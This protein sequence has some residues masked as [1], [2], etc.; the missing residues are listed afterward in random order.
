[1]KKSI[2]ILFLL[3]VFSVGFLSANVKMNLELGPVYTYF[4]SS[5]SFDGGHKSWTTHTGGVNILFGVEFVKNFGVY[6][7]ANFA[8][9]KEYWDKFSSKKHYYGD[10]EEVN[11]TYA[12]DSQFGFFYVFRPIKKLDLTLGAGIGIG[13]SGYKHTYA[14][15]SSILNAERSQANIGGGINFTV[16]Y[17]FTKMVGIYGGV[18]DTLYAPVYIKYSDGK[19]KPIESTNISGKIAN[20]FNI[21]AG[22]QLVF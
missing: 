7:N 17:M 11:L 5:A 9:G 15:A 22:I 8:F 20:S 3:T 18:S 19:T 6:V 2:C 21:K 10:L 16:S 4:G 14:K 13:G 12:I 1:M